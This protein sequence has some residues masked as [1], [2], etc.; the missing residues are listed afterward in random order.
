MNLRFVI[1]TL[2][3]FFQNKLNYE[4]KKCFYLKCIIIIM[5]K[6]SNINV[7][8]INIKKKFNNDE[9]FKKK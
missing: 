8:C 1:F 6:F 4:M 3:L 7:I 5:K 2:L 9:K